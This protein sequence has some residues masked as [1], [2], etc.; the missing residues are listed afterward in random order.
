MN[1]SAHTFQTIR[2]PRLSYLAAAL[3]LL[4]LPACSNGM[5][6]FDRIR[7]SFVRDD[8]H[9]WMGPDAAP[10]AF[11]PVWRH[12][13]T[14]EERR[15]RDLAYPLIEPPM[16]R[17]RW[18]SAIPE[19][20]LAARGWPYL[21]DRTAYSSRLFQTHYRSQNARYN[22]LMEDIRNDTVRLEPFFS[23]ART[24]ADLDSK[25][26][27][28]MAYVSNLTPEE[29]GNTVQRMRENRAIIEWVQASLRERTAGYKIALERL[30]IAAPSQNAVEIERTLGQ[31]E[32]QIGSYRA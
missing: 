10:T 16:D 5:G 7:P 31:L 6:D 11:D 25:R 13:L 9:S 14:E 17:N 32:R 26:E 23:I 18:Y 2:R 28:A 19:S 30:V 27:K 4:L 22:K 24:V 15:L 20:G 21:P 8:I 1:E 12:Q 29:H 3:L